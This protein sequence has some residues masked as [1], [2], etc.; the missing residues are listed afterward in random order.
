MRA[1]HFH[2]VQLVGL[3]GGG[4]SPSLALARAR[5]IPRHLESRAMRLTKVSDAPVPAA[6][7]ATDAGPSAEVAPD[8][9]VLS[10]MVALM[11]APVCVLMQ[12]LG[13]ALLA[14]PSMIGSCVI[15]KPPAEI[16]QDSVLINSSE[17]RD[18]SNRLQL[19]DICAK[20]EDGLGI[21]GNVVAN[22]L[23]RLCR[24]TWLLSDDSRGV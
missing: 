3:H 19:P 7:A 23:T 14:V 11:S 15:R 22:S 20:P 12:L 2:L 16:L 8:E 17:L 21:A 24:L 5:S 10:P 9:I 1:L 4:P 13:A 18:S 6:P